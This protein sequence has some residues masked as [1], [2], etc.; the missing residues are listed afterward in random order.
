MRWFRTASK[1]FSGTRASKNSSTVDS[2]AVYF[3]TAMLRTCKTVL[4]PGWRNLLEAYRLDSVA[5]VYGAT[6]GQVVTRSGSTEVRRISLEMEG[7]QTRVIFLKK[8]WVTR[9]SQ[10]WSGMLRGTFLGRSKARR[11]FENLAKLRHWGLDAP[12]P[13]AFG[14]EREV[15]WL[16]RS[17]LISASVPSPMPLDIYVRERLP[18]K[19]SE[20]PG[21]IRRTLLESLAGAT[22]R[23]HD[24][25]FVHHDYS[26]RNIILSGE[27]LDRFWLID[28]HK[29]RQW[30]V[31]AQHARAT[32]LAALDAPAPLYFRRTERLRFFLKYCGQ[33][34]LDPAARRLLRMIL[35][36]AEPMR[37]KQRKRVQDV[38]AAQRVT[39]VYR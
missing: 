33:Q 24:H 7:G 35:R 21:G 31:R 13:I 2:G 6:V 39:E 37:A 9:P 26:W 12:E 30:R 14:E 17:Y 27:R 22:R 38:K 19:K 32:D 29:G 1:L 5:G 15:R 4:S 18:G 20:D 25:Q 3:N 28:A 10:L 8:Y 23:L 34:R 16:L 11:E 36:L